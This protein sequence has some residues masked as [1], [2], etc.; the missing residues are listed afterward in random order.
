MVQ[1]E[2]SLKLSS[3][4]TFKKGIVGKFPPSSNCHTP[5]FLAFFAAGCVLLMDAILT[6]FP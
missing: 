5:V 4:G 3:A 6:R 2:A 1:V